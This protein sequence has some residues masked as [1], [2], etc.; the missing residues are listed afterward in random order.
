VSIHGNELAASSR[1]QEAT[2][3]DYAATSEALG[4]EGNLTHLQ[5]LAS[6]EHIYTSPTCPRLSA[7]SLETSWTLSMPSTPAWSSLADYHTGVSDPCCYT[8]SIS[9]PS[10]SSVAD[11]ELA[12][13]TSAYFPFQGAFPGSLGGGS[14][15]CADPVSLPSVVAEPSRDVLHA[16]LPLSDFNNRLEEDDGGNRLVSRLHGRVLA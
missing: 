14:V 15:P 6:A 7:S 10:A 9:P 13:W 3:Q 12:K 2:P 8:S 1:L 4:F 11:M 16:E 5:A